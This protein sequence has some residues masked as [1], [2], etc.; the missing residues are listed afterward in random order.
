MWKK[1]KKAAIILLQRMAHQIPF[2]PS[3]QVCEKK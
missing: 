3:P 1:I 2:K